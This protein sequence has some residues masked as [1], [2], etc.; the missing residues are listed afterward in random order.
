MPITF[1]DVL[2]DQRLAEI[3]S[4]EYLR[5]AA[6]RAALPQHPALVYGGDFY[7]AGS[8]TRKIS[9]V[10]LDGYDLPGAVAEG[11][12]IVPQA[13]ADQQFTLTVARYG[14]AYQPTDSVR[15]TDP[16]GIFNP[17]RFAEDAV[18]S[19][20]MRLTNLIA[21]LV[22][23]FSRAAATTSGTN[24]SVAT[25]LV[26]IAD[27][28]VGS[29]MAIPEGA[30]MAVLHTQQ[31]A[32]LRDSMAT[33]TSGAIQ[34]N[35]TPADIAIKGLGY[36]GRH[37]GVDTFASSHVPSANAGADRAGG[38]FL[39]GGIAWADMS[40]DPADANEIAIARKILFSRVRDALAGTTAYASQGY[41][42]ATRGYD[43][44]PHQMGAAIITDL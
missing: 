33:A 1:A 35:V 19:F 5:L 34:W 10:G 32:D 12:S 25:F 22:G 31:A 15:F 23:G 11:A 38:M 27:L 39:R 16:L 29:L 2:T 26:A 7:G 9:L 14:K 28:E 18:Q 40:V 20:L 44:A 42:G 36:R 41:L 13:L 43:T 3:L 21:N 30:A 17:A 8:L 4:G 6:D 24:L 37:F